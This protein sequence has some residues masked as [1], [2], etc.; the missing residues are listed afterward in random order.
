MEFIKSNGKLYSLSFDRYHGV[1]LP[2]R[3]M[4]KIVGISAKYA[5]E[6]K[7]ILYENKDDLYEYNWTTAT[8]MNGDKIEKQ[9][10]IV[11]T[12][13][14]KDNLEKNISLFKA[15]ELKYEPEVFVVKDHREAN[16]IA[17]SL[18]TEEIAKDIIVS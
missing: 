7:K 14:S 16:R 3:I 6:V 10:V 4:K 1:L 15:P 17:V 18:L 11:Y 9:K 2:E 12:T 8:K 13:E 5:D